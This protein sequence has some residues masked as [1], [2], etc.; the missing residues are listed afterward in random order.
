M[1]SFLLVISFLL[2]IITISGI[3]FLLKQIQILRAQ[4]HTEDLP[5]LLESY[6]GEIKAENKRL[7]EELTA[8]PVK[9]KPKPTYKSDSQSKPQPNQTIKA[10]DQKL[11]EY[12]APKTDSMDDKV[13][14]S[15]QSRIL[16]LHQSG[17]SI[18]EIA[19][20][21]NCGKTEAELTVKL[22]GKN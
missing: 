2:H 16:Q 14:A 4:N 15:L 22:H 9:R 21:L 10:V 3:Y 5:E 18:E 11:D 1:T 19:R 6:L 20:K 7:Q 17:F 12:P 13:Q 8:S